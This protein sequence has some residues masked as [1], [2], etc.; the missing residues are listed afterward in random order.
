[1]DS[2]TNLTTMMIEMSY[3]I[4]DLEND[5][6]W[7]RSIGEKLNKIHFRNGHWHAECDPNTG[8]CEVHY[9]K[10]DP[11]ESPVSLLKH[12]VQSPLGALVLGAA[13][14]GIFFLGDEV[15]NDGKIRKKSKKFFSMF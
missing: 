5:S 10:H 8:F 4:E 9:D 7:I 13:G 1:M 2:P 3:R 14:V 6:S 11:Y 15:L 12:M